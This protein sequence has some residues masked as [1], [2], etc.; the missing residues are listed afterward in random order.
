MGRRDIGNIFEWAWV[1]GLNGLAF[2]G[3]NSGDVW[4]SVVG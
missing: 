1:D 3:W 2:G 4:S